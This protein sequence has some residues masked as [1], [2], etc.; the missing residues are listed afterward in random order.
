MVA[1]SQA[2][3]IEDHF[4]NMQQDI[5]GHSAAS[6]DST[7]K[8]S[9][10]HAGLLSKYMPDGLGPDASVNSPGGY[11]KFM[12]QNFK[13]MKHG[14]RHG[15][16]K[17]FAGIHH[18]ADDVVK[19]DTQSFAVQK[20]LGT[21]EQAPIAAQSQDDKA[22]TS[23]GWEPNPISSSTWP[24]V[25]D[26]AIFIAFLTLATLLGVR[27]RRYLRPSALMA[28]SVEHGSGRSPSWDAK[29]LELRPQILHSS[30]ASIENAPNIREIRGIEPWIDVEAVVAGSMV[31]HST[32]TREDNFRRC[33]WNHPSHLGAHA[34]TV[35]FAN[36][37]DAVSDEM[38]ESPETSQADDID[39][40]PVLEV[41]GKKIEA[42]RGSNLRKV[43]LAHDFQLYG[44]MDKLMNCNGAGQC[45]TCVVDVEDVDGTYD[46]RPDWM[47]KKLGPKQS[48]N[49]RMACF[50]QVQGDAKNHHHDE[51]VVSE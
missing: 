18:V 41:N 29:T 25:S 24:T 39:S 45:G 31:Q 35:C 14:D 47:T 33:G 21:A 34:S 6:Y 38:Q 43:L 48:A 9:H 19:E 42:E 49:A 44:G 22:F 17:A 40:V 13:S 32:A 23:V 51:E 27:V 5:A 12:A 2:T 28:T 1:G 8:H 36:A 50:T 37:S 16:A 26:S 15:V 20:L 11:N 10:Q 30:V 7:V 3:D 4:E 46:A